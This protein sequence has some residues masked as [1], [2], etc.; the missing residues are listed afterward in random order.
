[1]VGTGALEHI[2]RGPQARRH[3]EA[4]KGSWQGLSPSLSGGHVG[5]ANEARIS[6]AGF[7][8][9]FLLVPTNGA[10]IPS[11]PCTLGGRNSVSSMIPRFVLTVT[12]LCS[13]VCVCLR[14][15]LG[16]LSTV[17]VAQIVAQINSCRFLVLV[18]VWEKC[19]ED[20]W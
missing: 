10:L 3:S 6:T 4:Q 14:R 19:W 8:I 1:M 18:V 13:S 11:Q 5:C 20:V 2:F 12:E 15:Q 7:K 17:V 16:Q 9:A